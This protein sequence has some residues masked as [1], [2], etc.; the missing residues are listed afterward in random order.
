MQKIINYVC[1]HCGY[2]YATE[3]EAMVCEQ[4][5][6]HELRVIDII[7]APISEAVDGYPEKVVLTGEDGK[8]VW[9]K[10]EK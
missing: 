4:N 2:E 8:Y 6:K 3:E 9:Y 1:D 7:H 10:R 5:H